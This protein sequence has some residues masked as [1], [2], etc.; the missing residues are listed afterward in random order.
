M[1]R[2]F[3]IHVPNPF[4]HLAHRP[5]SAKSLQKFMPAQEA[6]VTPALKAA[7][8][9]FKSAAKAVLNKIF[10]PATDPRVAAAQA[11]VARTAISDL[12]PQD[13]TQNGEYRTALDTL[14]QPHLITVNELPGGKQ[15]ADAYAAALLN[16]PAIDSIAAPTEPPSVEALEEQV[17]QA[18]EQLFDDMGVKG[19][20]E[21]Q[22]T[23]P[24][25]STVLAQRVWDLKN[26]RSV[27]VI[28]DAEAART[29]GRSG[30]SVS[31]APAYNTLFVNT[32]RPSDF[33]EEALPAVSRTLE[34]VGYLSEA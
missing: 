2:I 15:A 11:C 16:P 27:Y 28:L 4:K 33:P 31:L 9:G 29:K 7:K 13:L 21:R 14:T 26:N 18:M 6:P 34:Y 24:D 5:P 22:C 10:K 1:P 12:K 8:P 30:I 19:Q 25:G 3:S 23:L 17:K 20:R 32:L